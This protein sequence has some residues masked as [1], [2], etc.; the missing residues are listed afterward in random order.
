MD[1][2]TTVI[3][4]AYPITQQIS[5][6]KRVHIAQ[7]AL[8]QRASRILLDLQPLPPCSAAGV[9]RLAAAS[10]SPARPAGRPP[11][12]RHYYQRRSY[13]CLC[14]CALEE[15]GANA[16][17]TL[18]GDGLEA[19]TIFGSTTCGW[20]RTATSTRGRQQSTAGNP[21]TK[22]QFGQFPFATP[23]ARSNLDTVRVRL[24]GSSAAG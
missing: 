19:T 4:G 13:F 9:G 6:R 18:T 21:E 11:F 2:D 1:S 8:D 20:D 16:V 24:G 15:A 22:P 5:Q 10:A 12:N 17:D 3:D 23:G 14:C 7:I